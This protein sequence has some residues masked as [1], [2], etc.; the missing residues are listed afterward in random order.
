MLESES[1]LPLLRDEVLLALGATER[2]ELSL[3][4]LY[5]LESLSLSLLLPLIS[6]LSLRADDDERLPDL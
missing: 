4:S 2:W 5:R 1:V 3:P 6:L